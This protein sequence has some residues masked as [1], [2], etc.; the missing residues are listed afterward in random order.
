MDI[1]EKAFQGTGHSRC[2]N[3]EEESTPNTLKGK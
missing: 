3:P 1:R 2:K